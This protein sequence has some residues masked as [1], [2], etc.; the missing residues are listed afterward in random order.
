MYSDAL[1]M[2]EPSAPTTTPLTLS[3]WPGSPAGVTRPDAGADAGASWI[4]C[5]AAERL[6]RV[7][8]ATI[9]TRETRARVA[10]NK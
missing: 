4:D 6:A 8:T 1:R 9:E 2:G 5:A 7:R 3:A 10:S